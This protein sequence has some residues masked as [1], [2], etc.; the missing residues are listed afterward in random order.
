MGRSD[1]KSRDQAQ[2]TM[3]EKMR[4]DGKAAIVTGAG[5]GLG[6]AVALGRIGAPQEI[7]EIVVWLAFD[8]SA[9]VTGSVMV[10]DGGQTLR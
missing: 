9:F 5:K 6:R 8:A 7:E 10:I 2:L 3:F 1:Q 4:L